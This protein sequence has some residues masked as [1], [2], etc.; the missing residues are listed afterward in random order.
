MYYA[1]V[2]HSSLEPM[3]ASLIRYPKIAV[4]SSPSPEANGLAEAREIGAV[5]AKNLRISWGLGWGPISDVIKLVESKGVRVFFVNEYSEFLDG[6]ACW[7]AGIPYIFLNQNV[8]DPARLR[9]DVAHEL[10]HLVMHRDIAF[11]A[12]TDIIEA[13]AFGFAIE[14]LAPWQTLEAE[15]PSIP[16]LP[17]LGKLRKRWKVSM[18]SIVRHMHA[19]NAITDAAYANAFRKFSFLGYRRGPEPVWVDPDESVIHKYFVAAASDKQIDIPK[20]AESYGIS[21]SVLGAM[22]PAT[23]GKLQLL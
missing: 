6:F 19:N 13:M 22:I 16:D 23:L 15:V 2:G 5:I 7:T 18:Q 21:D 20:L 3:V 10:G 12:R 11:D 1:V 8:T 4:P 9:L 17:L 14:F